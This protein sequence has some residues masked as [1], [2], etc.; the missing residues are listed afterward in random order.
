M[1]KI[2]LQA[3]YQPARRLVPVFAA[4]EGVQDSAMTLALA[5]AAAAEGETVLVLDAQ[6]GIFM[7]T[8]GIIYNKTLGD[9]LYHGADID[10]VKY[11]TSNE[12]F[13][14]MACGDAS[15]DDVLGSLAALSLSYDWVFVAPPTG[16]T[17]AHTRL[18]AAADVSLITYSTAGDR[19][20]RAYWMMDAIRARAPRFDPILLSSGPKVEAAE[21]AVM[22]GETVREFLGA[23]PIYAGHNDDMDITT[24]LLDRM[25]LISKARQVA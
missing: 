6:T 16:C 19:F 11:V 4:S 7:K 17:P 10:D 15:L 23:P 14:A 9:V 5:K 13:T 3:E 21:T 1:P 24:R 25:R 18:A 12:H 8:A 2:G 22:L 20:M